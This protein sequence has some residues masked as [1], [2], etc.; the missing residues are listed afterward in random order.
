MRFLMPLILALL[1]LAT[2]APAALASS[3]GHYLKYNIYTGG[4]KTISAD[5][6]IVDDDASA[7][8]MIM[9][10]RTEG[11]LKIF[12][13][14]QGTLETAGRYL[15]NGEKRPAFHESVSIW[16]DN[17]QVK[18]F[19]WNEQGVLRDFY[20]FEDGKTKSLEDFN[21]DQNIAENSVDILTAALAIM[22]TAART[23]ACE[24]QE[25]VFDGKRRFALSVENKGIEYLKSSR[26]NR[27]GG[28]ALRCEIKITP[29]QGDW[30]GKLKG[31]MAIS[32]EGGQAGA[33][34]T[35]W[36][37]R[38]EKDGPAVPV[39]LQA[40]TSYGTFMMH[41]AGYNKI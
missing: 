33:V 20:V 37:A 36:L 24:G 23:G 25:D 31:W 38:L 2:G 15:Y 34:P 19:S 26:Y 9:N 4:L 7:Y 40:K 12:K 35:V 22:E 32:E 10:A 21:L 6:Q 39:K 27:Y 8:Q 3:E 28:E 29:Q 14:W 17:T 18:E 5:L 41:L 11:L 13:A 16:K 30:H 1:L